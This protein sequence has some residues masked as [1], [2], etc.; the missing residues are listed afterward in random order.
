MRAYVQTHAR[1]RASPH[2]NMSRAHAQITQNPTRQARAHTHRVQHE[3]LHT[4]THITAHQHEHKHTRG[5]HTSPPRRH[6]RAHMIQSMY[7]LA[8]MQTHPRVHL[9]MSP[10]HTRITR[11]PTT[12]ACTPQ[13]SQP[14]KH[15]HS[16]NKRMRA[17]INTSQH[18]T[19]RM[20]RSHTSPQQLHVHR[21]H[22]HA[23][24]A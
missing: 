12:S 4:C 14:N 18:E 20:R 16:H 24:K 17:C 7:M 13:A 10:A 23:K 1:A 19:K 2:L 22:V 3:C 6:A 11:K 8:Y 21:R 15:V 5:S 9:N